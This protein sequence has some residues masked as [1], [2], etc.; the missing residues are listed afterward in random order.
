MTE[1]KKRPATTQC[2]ESANGGLSILF[3]LFH[4]FTLGSCNQQSKS[5]GTKYPTWCPEGV[6]LHSHTP[7]GAE[8]NQE[9]HSHMSLSLMMPQK[10]W[11]F[12]TKLDKPESSSEEGGLVPKFM[13]RSD[14]A[15]S[16]SVP[17]TDEPNETGRD[18]ERHLISWQPFVIA[19]SKK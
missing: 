5:A 8:I 2:G 19:Y 9:P 10:Y 15:R 12:S 7:S 14:T 13:K 17:R 1:I 18:V 16:S 11:G 4:W 3:V 6:T